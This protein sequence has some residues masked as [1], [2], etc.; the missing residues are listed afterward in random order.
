[1]ERKPKDYSNGKIYCIRNHI[2]QPNICWKHL[3]EFK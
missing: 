3:P 1:M 2:G